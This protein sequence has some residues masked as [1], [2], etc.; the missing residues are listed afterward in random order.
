MH[1]NYFLQLTKN[2]RNL[3]HLKSYQNCLLKN[4]QIFMQANKAFLILKKGL[5]FNKNYYFSKF[6]GGLDYVC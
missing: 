2:F 4:K 5:S 1:C 6:M 3:F